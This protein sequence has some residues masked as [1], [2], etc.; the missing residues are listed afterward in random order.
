MGLRVRGP[1]MVLRDVRVDLGR[2]QVRVAQHRLDRAQ[3]GP[4][5][6]QVRRE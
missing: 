4:A 6:E 1:H 5:A 3:V 2:T